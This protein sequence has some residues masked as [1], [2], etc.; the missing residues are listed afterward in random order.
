VIAWF[1]APLGDLPVA[2]EEE[3]QVMEEEQEKVNEDEAMGGME[4]EGG[5]QR[6]G[7]QREEQREE[8]RGDGQEREVWNQEGGRL[9]V[10]SVPMLGSM[11]VDTK[12]RGQL[13]SPL[14]SLPL[15]RHAPGSNLVSDVTLFLW[16]V[17]QGPGGWVGIDE[18]GLMG[19]G[20]WW[21]WVVADCTLLMVVDGGCRCV[22]WEVWGC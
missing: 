4:R 3:A 22:P 18:W 6:E 19:G 10:S 21:W 14:S 1:T 7:G 9:P 13:M 20:R 5:G 11:T 2:V 16:V 15:T 12:H 8:E 17:R